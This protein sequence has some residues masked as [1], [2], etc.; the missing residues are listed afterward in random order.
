MIVIPAIDI[1]GG[2]CV[3]LKKGDYNQIE[4]YDIDPV[5]QARVFQSYGAKYLHVIDLD[6]AKA[7][8]PINFDIIN[9]IKKQTNIVIECGG[10]IRDI[11]AISI[12]FN[13][14]IDYII[15]GSIIFKNPKLIDRIF[16]VFRC[17]RFV[18]A[19]DFMDGFVKVSGWMEDTKISFE[20]GIK[21]I[22]RLGFKR[23]IYTDINTD[24][25]LM[26]H[27]LAE[28]QNI[29]GL[30]DGFLIASGGIS[31]IDDIKALKS[32]GVDGAIIGKALYEGKV[33]LDEIFKVI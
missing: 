11:E 18:A 19:V 3:R 33:Q 7:G 30:F 15:L 13:A 16:S 22:N 17:D 14:G 21:V 28:A 24:G 23:L 4:H 9:K 6:G 27:N 2:R 25:M 1:I 10:G 29:R 20:E 8:K 5:E 12:Y 32:I 31:S 26:G